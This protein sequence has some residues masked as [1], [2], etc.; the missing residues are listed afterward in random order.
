MTPEQLVEIIHDGESLDREFKAEEKRKGRSYHLAASTYRRLGAKD[1][2]VQQPGF[3]PFQQEQMV[4]QYV[5][6]HGSITRKEVGEL[7]K[8]SQPQ[9]YRL[10]HRLAKQGH[11]RQ[12][13][14]RG[15]SVRYEKRHR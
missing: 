14:S 6:R 15:R 12:V 10:L 4:L 13:G 1:A 8:V 11:L 2:Y 3:E 7:C 9:A 5:E